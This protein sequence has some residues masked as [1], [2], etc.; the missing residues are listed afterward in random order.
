[1]GDL[2]LD[3]PDLL[4]Q[5]GPNMSREGAAGFNSSKDPREFSRPYETPDFPVYRGREVIRPFDL[6][7]STV[8][9]GREVIRPLEVPTANPY[10]EDGP[11]Q[12]NGQ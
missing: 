6:P 12:D 3:Y 10:T 9:R 11:P 5:G 4:Y 1:M 2:N 7:N 8:Y